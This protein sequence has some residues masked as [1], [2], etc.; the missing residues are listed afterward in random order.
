MRVNALD[1]VNIRTADLAGSASFY[2]ELL[3]LEIGDAP[4]PGTPDQVRWLFSPD[5]RA[6]IHLVKDDSREPG[7]TGSIDHVAFNCSGKEDVLARM[8]KLGIEYSTYEMPSGDQTLVFT[9][10]PH[11][12]M[13]ELNFRGE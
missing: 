4:P 6:I 9:R 2:A 13:L 11:G 5:G 7:P 3:G 8:R 10:D 1:H 12:I